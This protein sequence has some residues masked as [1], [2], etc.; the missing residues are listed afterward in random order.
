[1]DGDHLRTSWCLSSVMGKKKSKGDALIVWWFLCFA[2]TLPTFFIRSTTHSLTHAHV[3]LGCA[4]INCDD[5]RDTVMDGRGVGVAGRLLPYLPTY[6]LKT[7]VR[8]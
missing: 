1:M 2:D 3:S 6:L 4:F 7:P 8:S 5:A